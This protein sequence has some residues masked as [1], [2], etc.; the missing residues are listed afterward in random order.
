M[1][2]LVELGG[3]DKKER[4]RSAKVLEIYRSGP[5]PIV[6]SGS[7]SG[8][9][10][11]DLPLGIKPECKDVADYLCSNGVADSD[12]RLEGDSVDTLGNFHFLRKGGYIPKESNVGLVTDPFHMPRAVYCAN[13]IFGDY[14]NFVPVPTEREVELKDKVM[15]GVYTFV[16]N[17]DL[18]K[19][20]D[21]DFDA[22]DY[23][24]DNQHPYY[25]KEFFKNKEFS[26]QG[27]MINRLR[28]M[29]KSKV[30]SIATCIRPTLEDSLSEED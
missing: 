19:I 20:K 27:L 29:D 25:G 26:W 28:K 9:I 14:A 30:A 16:M 21:G 22:M 10:G 15:E 4:H 11:P 1:D 3:E 5:L 7:H 13:K 18:R 8:L 2:I 23:F 17:L 12:L 6:V 24:M